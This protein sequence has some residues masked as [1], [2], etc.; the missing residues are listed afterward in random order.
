MRVISDWAMYDLLKSA[1]DNAVG[2]ATWGMDNDEIELYLV[3][4]KDDYS[5]LSVLVNPTEDDKRKFYEDHA[6]DGWYTEESD[7]Y[8]YLV[9]EWLQM[10]F[11]LR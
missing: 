5:E 3:A 11:D 7:D 8:L 10:G 4:V 2:E 9:D 1:F 6:G